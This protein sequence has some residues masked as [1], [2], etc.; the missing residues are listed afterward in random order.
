MGTLL[1]SKLSAN[2]TLTACLILGSVLAMALLGRL[3]DRQL[4]A[5]DTTVS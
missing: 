2:R 5:L 1:L 3:H 4:R